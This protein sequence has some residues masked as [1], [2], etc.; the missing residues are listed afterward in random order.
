MLRRTFGS[1]LALVAAT[2]AVIAIAPPSEARTAADNSAGANA[3]P[4]YEFETE[5]M[6]E[7][8]DFVLPLKNQGMLM[9]SEHGW[10]FRTG[11]Q[12]SHT[13]VTLVPGGLRVHDSGTREWRNLS[14]A[15]TKLRPN[16]GIAAICPVPDDISVQRPMLLEI[17]P[18][19]GD[20]YTDVSS[21]P[22]E[23]AVTV[24][25]DKGNDEAH[26]GAGPDFFNG[27]LGRDKAWGDGGNDWFRPGLGNDLVFGG[28]GDDD[29][30]AVDGRDRIR[31]GA[32]DDRLWGGNGGD[33][34]SGGD[35]A[36]FLLCGSGADVAKADYY[37]RVAAE[38]ESVTRN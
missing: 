6:S 18:R 16:R 24:L 37:D 2:A 9:R 13:V 23:F 38:C 8:G 21:L 11:Q 29:I 14:P 25:G 7:P 33:S 26:F 3:G 30:V 17:W 22:A 1:A 10:R 35:G 36:D 27:Y 12:D 19:L 31:G 32:G 15:C 5:L 4:P 20:D 28:P 34:I